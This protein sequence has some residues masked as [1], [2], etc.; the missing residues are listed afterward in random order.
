MKAISVSPASFG[1]PD[2]LESVELPIP[3]PGRGEVRIK[4]EAA[5]VHPAD[6][7]TRSGLF[8]AML[9]ERERFVLGW[10][11]AGTVDAI[12]TGVTAYRAGDAVIGLSDWLETFTGT[13]AEYVVL[14][15][16]ALMSAPEGF[17]FAEAATLPLDGL[18]A[19]QALDRLDLADGQTLVVVGAAGGVGGFAVSL[20]RQRGLR[21]VGVAGP[22]DEEFVTGLGADFVPRSTDIATAVR[23]LHPAGVDGLLDT[24]VLGERALGAVRDNGVYVTLLP[25]A[26]PAAERG[27][28]VDGVMVRSDPS[29]LFALTRQAELGHLKLRVAGTYPF[30]A[31]AEAHARLEKRG[32]RGHLI[33]VP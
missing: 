33:L 11:L 9:P 24:A 31:A 15:A 29:L 26:A 25:M 1:G 32:T 6:L 5:A 17:S 22:Q 10:D 14:K 2:V 13:Q 18:T 16:D 4:V 7:G 21:V 20:A 3:E 12:G 8:A 27:I 19:V 30:E 28:R 23:A